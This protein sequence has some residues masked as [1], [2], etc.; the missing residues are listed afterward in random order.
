[1]INPTLFQYSFV[2][3]RLVVHIITIN[4]YI[5]IY[6]AFVISLLFDLNVAYWHLKNKK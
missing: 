6:M 4:K 5:Y 3:S 1:M 2:Y